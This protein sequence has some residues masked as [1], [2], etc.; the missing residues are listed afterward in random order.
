MPDYG[1]AFFFHRLLN[2]LLPFGIGGAF[3]IDPVPSFFSPSNYFSDHGFYVF[4]SRIRP[5]RPGA[6][7]VTQ[8]M[9][10]RRQR[11]LNAFPYEGRTIDDDLH[12]A[13]LGGIHLRVDLLRKYF[14]TIRLDDKARTPATPFQAK[15]VQGYCRTKY[16]MFRNIDPP[17]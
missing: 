7:E 11:Q 10:F 6:R 17:V 3:L 12:P 8:V 15:R 4:Q 1:D 2:K 5:Q 13:M 14:L 16:S 9:G